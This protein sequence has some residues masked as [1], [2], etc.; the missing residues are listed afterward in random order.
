MIYPMILK[1]RQIL[2]T[3]RGF[4]IHGQ[5]QILMTLSALMYEPHLIL[6]TNQIFY[7]KF[8]FV[9]HI[10][11]RF[12]TLAYMFIAVLPWANRSVGAG[13]SLYSIARLAHGRPVLWLGTFGC[14]GR[15]RVARRFA[16]CPSPACSACPRSR[17][18]CAHQPSRAVEEHRGVPSGV[19]RSR[20]GN[21]SCPASI[22]VCVWLLFICIVYICT[23]SRILALLA[24]VYCLSYDFK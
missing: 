20:S 21:G 16:R 8:Y 3:L 23:H 24:N 13:D 2:Q 4:Y 1:K 11:S 12:Y 6:Y 19:S 17:G 9:S 22:F 5:G 14:A 10:E 18:A 15:V 7:Q